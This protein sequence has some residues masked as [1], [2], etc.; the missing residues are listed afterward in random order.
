MDKFIIQTEAKRCLECKHKPC[1]YA[2][3]AHN[4][5]PEYMSK[6]KQGL[7]EEARTIWHS[8]SN[9]PELCGSLCQNE[10]MCEGACTLNKIHK[11]VKIGFIEKGVSELFKEIVDYPKDKIN[12]RH[13][14]IGLGPAGIANAL[15]MAEYGYIV[16][17][18]DSNALLGGTVYNLVPDFRFDKSILNDIQHKFDRLGIKI[19]YNTYVGKDV[20]LIDLIHQYDTI[21]IADGL[22]LPSSVDIQ[23]EHLK[24]YY[25]QDLLNKNIYS[26]KDLSAMLGDKIYIV[27][28]GNVAIDMA[29]TLRRLHKEVHI[30]Y[31]RTIEDAP[32]GKSEIE[33]AINE[34]VTIHELIG[35]VSYKMKN[36]IKLLNCEKTCLV[37]STTGGRGLVQ[38]VPN[39]ET[40][41]QIDDLIFATG[42]KTSEVLFHDSGVVQTPEISPFATNYPHIFVG[43]DRI[44]KNKRIVDAM[45]TGLTVAN[46]I[47][48]GSYE[49][50]H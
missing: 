3:P 31:R 38:R 30:I 18:I 41:F 7:W 33:A 19:R 23:V 27:G 1:V 47:A 20:L 34:G 26:K 35:P 39:S 42:Q 2:C 25:A 48:K 8:T 13:L 10:N 32:A 46:Q 29:R 44:N 15:K 28:L 37:Q 40:Y 21:F 16:E 12:H 14:V 50:N 36:K 5:I 11:P 49:T 22:G 6:I 24:V 45:V 4:N 9:L 43:G 17:A